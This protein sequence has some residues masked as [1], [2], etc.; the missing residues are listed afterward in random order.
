[1]AFRLRPNTENHLS[2]YRTQ[3]ETSELIE[4]FYFVRFSGY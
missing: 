2:I 3:L 4:Y 1:M